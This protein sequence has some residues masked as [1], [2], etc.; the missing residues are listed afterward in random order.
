MRNVFFTLILN[1]F[2]FGQKPPV[3]IDGVAAI[4]EDKI[5]LK[6]DLNQM[7]NMV[8]IQKGIN[9]NLNYEAFL[10]LQSSVL[11]SMIDQKIL[12]KL[13]EED[14]TIEVKDKDVNNALDQQLENLILQSGGKKQAEK[15]LGQTLKSFESEFWFEMKD[16]MVSEMFQ[17]KVL[18]NI[19]TNKKDVLSFYSTYKDSLP[20]F[21][22]EVKMRHILIKP[23]PSDSVKKKIVY[24]LSNIKNKIETEDNDFSFYAKE[25]SMDP[26][27]KNR[28][29][30]LGWYGRGELVKNFETTAFTVPLNFIS[31]PFETEMGYHIL[32]TLDKKGDKV[33]VRH[34]LIIPQISKKDEEKAYKFAMSIKDSCKTLIDFKKLSKKYSDDYQT[35][36]VGGDLG[37]INPKTYPIKELGKIIN[38]IQKNECSIPINTSFGFHLLWLENIKKGGKPTLKEHWSKIEKM[39]LNNKKMNWYNGWIKKEKEKFFIKINTY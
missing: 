38:S 19:K 22:L 37:W 28:G 35:S 7:T 4:V 23:K 15:M 2:L 24:F 10:G 21:P 5:V 33:K 27:S 13:A 34:I 6:S 31:D 11:E 1:L 20:F 8:A 30:N 16:K 32:E 9:P 26:G 18:S 3:Y 39:A 29:G 14:T 17:Q 12:L 36:G 25:H